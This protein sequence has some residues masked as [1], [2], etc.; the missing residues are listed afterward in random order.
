MC[1]V[2]SAQVSHETNTFSV[3]TLGVDDFAARYL[4]RGADIA[5]NMAGTRTEIGA[6]LD[7]AARHGWDLVQPIATHATPAGPA[8]P[9]AWAELSG[10]VLDACDDRI[11]GVLLALHGAMVTVDRDDAEGDLLARLRDRLG[12]DVPIAITM[13][14][15]AN[16]TD[17]MARHADIVLAYRTYPHIDQ[18]EIA[19]EAAD[20]L[21]R[22]MAGEIRPV[23]T[24][25]RRPMLTGCNNGV[26]QTGPMV[27]F[28]ARAAGMVAAER[29]VLA[30]TVCAGFPWADLA[31]TGPSV[32]VVSD[33]APRQDLAESLM[34]DVW[35]R[36]DER[37]VA[38]LSLDEAM[39][40][41][42]QAVVGQ[43]LVIG[44]TTDNPGGGGY[45][46]GV[47]LL[48]AMLD[49]GLQNAALAA[50]Y[51]P[52]SAGRAIDGGVGAEVALTLGARVDPA[53]YGP[54]LDVTGTVES[55]SDGAFVCEGP[56]WA[57]IK[58][59]LGPTA[60]VRIGGVRVVVASN[61]LQVTDRNAFLSQ[62]IDPATCAVVAVK[63]SHHFRAAFQPLA[64][65][66]VVCDSGGLVSPD[67]ARFPYRKVRRPIWP[68]DDLG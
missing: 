43:P 15:H 44:D 29:E 45:G 38:L 34:D 53:G 36:R 48:R 59:S 64:G 1:R 19:T 13:D 57:G 28:L 66:V 14:L 65:E 33:G 39:N 6:H 67:F 24:V 42:R 32:T 31:A 27:D 37:T 46:D 63:S 21:Q 51:D 4:Y 8:R 17:A 3:I 12:P 20:L 10:A 30:V 61:N 58:V 16:V 50:I 52:E 41:A 11:D 49:A 9:E 40:R 55:V 47:A 18:H 56:M 23:S 68:L 35:A 2:L 54:A 22:A 62:G 25:A 7:A 5:A 60:V 26:T